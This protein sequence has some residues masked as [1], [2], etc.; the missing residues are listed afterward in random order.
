[1][2]CS[3]EDPAEID[4]LVAHYFQALNLHRFDELAEVFTED[5][6]SDFSEETG[7]VYQGLP[8]ILDFVTKGIGSHTA[9]QLRQRPRIRG[10]HGRKGLHPGRLG[11]SRLK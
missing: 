1:M 10:H 7:V 5:A 11:R 2:L 9:S 8:E 6:I 3:L 4:D